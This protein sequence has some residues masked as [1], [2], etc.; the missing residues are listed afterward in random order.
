MKIQ[1]KFDE[2]MTGALFMHLHNK[3][4]KESLKLGNLRIEFKNST[5]LQKK[6]S[7]Q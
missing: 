1:A 5:E 2:W 7:R 6:N 4:T 3:K